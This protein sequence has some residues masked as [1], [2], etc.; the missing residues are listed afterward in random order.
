VRVALLGVGDI[1]EQYVRGLA[2]FPQAKLVA[3]ADRDV[4]RSRARGAEWGVHGL[5]PDELL[6]A[7]DVELVVNLTPPRA[8]VETT[9]AALEAG[10]TCTRRSRLR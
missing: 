4:E 9:R 8:H 10:S 2:Q 1:A 6:A 7:G 5:A 3:V